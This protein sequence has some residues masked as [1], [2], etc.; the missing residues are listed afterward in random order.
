MASFEQK[1]ASFWKWL[2]ENGVYLSD[3]IA[4]KDYREEG[5]GRGVVAAKDIKEGDLLFSIPRRVLLSQLTSSIRSV[6][7]IVD[8]MDQLSGWN[9]LILCLMYESQKEDSLWKPYFDI[10][11]TTFS[12][13]M[14]WSEDELKELEGT[15]VI[16][17]IGKSEAEDS[18]RE[19]ILP[20]IQ[21]YDIF[22]EK[23][24]TMELFHR[25]GSLIMAYSFHDELEKSTARKS[26]K[27]EEDEDED[28]DEDEEGLIAMVPLA[29]MLN[30]KTGHNNAR[31]FHETDCLQM[32]AIK[33]IKEGEQ[34]YNTYGDLCNVDLLRKYGFTDDINEFDIAEINISTIVECCCSGQ[35]ES[36]IDKK[37]ELLMEEEVYDDCYVIDNQCEIP[38]EMMIAVQV[39]QSSLQEFKAIQEKGKLP[40]PR[41]TKEVKEKLVSILNK[42]LDRYPTTLEV[43]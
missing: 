19:H 16:E 43:I 21:K 8:D 11:P 41:L 42:R 39:L 30:H 32:K 36:L 29:D 34:I 38:D 20:I 3:T 13:P 33:D 40:K 35:K 6:E 23:I 4:I 9:P 10:L 17:K 7:G 28:E 1:S 18:Y 12:T 31:L 5:A 2:Q 14:F 22:D 27:E 37:I 25:C 24:H 26:E 15:D